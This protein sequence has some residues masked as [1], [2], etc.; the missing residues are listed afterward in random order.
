[1]V[2]VVYLVFVTPYY[3]VLGTVVV[4]GVLTVVENFSGNCLTIPATIA[5]DIPLACL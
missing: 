3:F 4:D 1:M 5:S 2:L